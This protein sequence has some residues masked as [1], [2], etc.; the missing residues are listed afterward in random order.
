MSYESSKYLLFV[1]LQNE[2]WK[3]ALLFYLENRGQWAV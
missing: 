3:E 1:I 2:Y